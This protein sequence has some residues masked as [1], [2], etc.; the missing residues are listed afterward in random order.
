M[1]FKESIIVAL[2]IFLVT[3]LVNINHLQINHLYENIENLEERINI[4]QFE[5]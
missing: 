1:D 4:I 5:K 3:I 2:M